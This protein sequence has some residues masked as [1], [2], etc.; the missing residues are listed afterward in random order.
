M[1][2]KRRFFNMYLTTTFSVAMVLFLIGLESMVLLSAHYLIADMRENLA[3]TI[4]L[5]PNADSTSVS[6]LQNVLETMPSTSSY[7]FISKQQ[8]LEEHIANLGEDPTKF[9]GY[10]PLYDTYELHLQPV[11]TNHD[12]IPVIT[13]KLT[14]LPYV[15][16]VLYQEDIVKVLDHNVSRVSFVLAVC[17][18]LLLIIA[19]MLIMNTIRLHIYSKRFT[20]NTMRL[21]GATS[22]VIR[23]PFIGRSMRMGLEAAVLTVLVLAGVYY[24]V[25]QSLHVTIF[26][27]TLE[28][29]GIVVLTVLL[30]GLIIT[31][32]ASLVATG[33]YVRMK[34]EKMYEI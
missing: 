19:W 7:T 30:S 23:R 16:K 33:R 5:D 34:V 9:L 21:V 17:A 31:F 14:S 4:I 28:N 6:R 18:L 24:Y 1:K 12:S 3:L 26:P 15:E 27:P 8:A 29:I 2:Q 10:N 13:E 11:Y 20:I 22:W 25:M 32:L